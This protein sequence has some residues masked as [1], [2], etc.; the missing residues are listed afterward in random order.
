MALDLQKV[1]QAIGKIGFKLEFEIGNI[2]R[3]NG[4]HLISNRCYID[5][6]EGT[7]REIDL[8]A[9]KV[10]IVEGISVYTVIIVSCKKAKRTLG[11]YYLGLSSRMIQTLTGGHLKGG[12]I[13]QQ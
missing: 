3:L 6:L 12:A 11:R 8:L 5:D 10:N 1:T 13:I 9:Y 4:W 7:V 2:L